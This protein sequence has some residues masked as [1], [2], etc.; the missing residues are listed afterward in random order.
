MEWFRFYDEVLD[1]PRPDLI[2]EE[3]RAHIRALHAETVE[4]QRNEAP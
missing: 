2:G 1:D 4:A 3:V